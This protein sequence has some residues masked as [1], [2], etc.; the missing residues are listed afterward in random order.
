MSEEHL[1]QISKVAEVLHAL[2][3]A[4]Q[5]WDGDA[6]SFREALRRGEHGA[7]VALKQA[8]VLVELGFTRDF[9]PASLADLSEWEVAR[10]HGPLPLR[11]LKSRD[12]AR[13]F[14]GLADGIEG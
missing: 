2:A 8:E 3:P 7:L 10:E 5:P 13:A 12:A 14:Y 4:R 11:T 1:L 9:L 6:Y